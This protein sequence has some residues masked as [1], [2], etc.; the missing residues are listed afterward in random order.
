MRLKK[1]LAFLVVAVII[2]SLIFMMPPE[3]RNGVPRV[4]AVL[5]GFIAFMWAMNELGCG[6][7]DIGI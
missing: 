6:G 1:M 7:G 4:L 2:V 5:A 3:A